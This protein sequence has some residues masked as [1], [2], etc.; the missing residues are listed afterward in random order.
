MSQAA[1]PIIATSQYTRYNTKVARNR[2]TSEPAWIRWSLIAV[3][4]IFLSLFLFVPLAAVFTEGLRKG[5]ATYIAAIVE[6]DALSSIKLTLI[7]AAIA[8]PLN[9][10]FG[11]AAA[12]AIA[13]FEF[14]GKSIL[15]TLIDLPFAVSPV[16][17][18]LIYVLIFGLQGWFGEW[19]SDH[20]IR[21]IFAVP[22]IV[23]ATLFVAFP[24]I[25]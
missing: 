12:W 15:I 5:F 8:L 13:K 11:L 20:D 10:V 24:F 9:L 18:G 21:V 6:P 19:L 22:G 1:A 25:A 4:L 23:L 7:A 14:K 17:A 3:A 16:I 2:A